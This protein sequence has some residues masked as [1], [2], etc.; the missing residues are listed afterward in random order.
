[1]RYLVLS[2]IHS[3]IEALEACCRQAKR[4]VYDAVLCCG[5]LVG[6][7]PN[8]NETL[9]MVRELNPICIR[10]NHERVAAGIGEPE[11]FT[12][13]ARTSTFWTRRQ[14]T[15]SSREYLASLPEGPVAVN[16]QAQLVHGALTD[17]DD[18]IYT[19]LEAA[20][21][22]LLT[23]CPITFF[24]H[25]HLPVVYEP[26]RRHR[27]LDDY[28]LEPETQILVNPGSVG[29]PRD[30]DPRASFL[31]WDVE[32]RR[33]EFYRV[34]YAVKRTQEKMRQAELPDYLTNRLT[35]GR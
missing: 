15:D 17:E 19:G 25:T 28:E 35:L 6:Y 12:P 13:N 26:L 33:L 23:E 14:L 1:M 5:D 4:E 9:D 21:N 34:E 10:G 30:G 16:A 11:H 32:E 20:E 18:Y 24:G 3:N 8:P 29:Q 31:I 7:G 2:D 27:N 22:F